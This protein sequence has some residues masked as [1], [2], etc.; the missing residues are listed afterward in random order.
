MV[1]EETAQAAP[2]TVEF[3]AATHRC[4]EKHV[5]VATAGQDPRVV[6]NDPLGRAAAGRPAGRHLRFRPV[7]LVRVRAAFS[8][9]AG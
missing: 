1:P 4:G 5:V 7:V 9:Y 6:V 8:G 3:S 2:H